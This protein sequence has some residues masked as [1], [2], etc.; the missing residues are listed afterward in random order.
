MAWQTLKYQLSSSAP[1]IMHNGQMAD[2]MNKWSIALKKITSKKVKTDADHEE[3]ARIK[4]LASLYLSPDGPILPSYVIEATLI[5]AAKK[6]KEG[7]TAKSAFF[8]PT[9]A[10]LE[11]DGPRDANSLWADE[12]FRFFA[13]V[14][15]NRARVP[16]MRP[17]FNNWTC[18][19][20]VSVENTLANP[21]RVDEWMN[22]A[23]TQVGMCDWRPRYGRFTAQ[24]LNE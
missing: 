3:I 10:T 9:H 24:R 13:L 11:Y 2:P 15:V 22:V 20:E 16:N 12:Q 7:Q 6:T 5:N 4:F 23:G 1:L 17:V 19:V 21:S 14:V 18:T 8:C